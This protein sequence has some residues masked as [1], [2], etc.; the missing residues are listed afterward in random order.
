V[1]HQIA[2]N[3]SLR[4]RHFQANAQKVDELIRV[5]VLQKP[6]ILNGFAWVSFVPACPVSLLQLGGY[7]NQ[8]IFRVQQAANVLPFDLSLAIFGKEI[9]DCIIQQVGLLKI[10]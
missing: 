1:T 2:E 7:L 10:L 3:R 4:M 8:D 6:Y 9:L 5:P